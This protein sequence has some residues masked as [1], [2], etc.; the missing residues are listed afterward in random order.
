MGNH[1]I[2]HPCSLNT[3]P[4]LQ[5][6]TL[7]RI[8]DDVIEAKRRLALAFPGQ[9]ENSFAY[10]CYES[11]VGRGVTRQ[12]YVPVIARHFDA[13]RARGTSMRGNHPV[14]ADLCH[15]SSW[16]AER[17]ST[18]EMIGLVEECA[19]E[20]WWGIFTFHG[21]DQG[22]LPISEH[23]LCGL[24]DHLVRSPQRVWTAPVIEVAHYVREQTLQEGP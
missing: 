8:E 9:A 6:W 17:M 10:P 13:A 16:S 12:S 22:H 20:G 14:Y 3:S 21:I 1:T 23:D 4:T 18:H 15:L 11:D 7:E 24:L 2:A 5:S 19:V